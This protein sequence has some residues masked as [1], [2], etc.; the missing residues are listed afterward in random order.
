MFKTKRD[1]SSFVF[2]IE[3]LSQNQQ[4][5]VRYI[6]E[7]KQQLAGLSD[8]FSNRPERK[9]LNSLQDALSQLR[10]QFEQVSVPPEA[11][12]KMVNLRRMAL[13]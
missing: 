3:Q 2:K 12:V 4:V 5:M 6:A 7:I 8:Q 11:P 13:S 9:Q 1:D 10:R